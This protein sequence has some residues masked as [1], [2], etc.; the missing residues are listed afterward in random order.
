M[1]DKRTLS[2]RIIA[3]LGLLLTIIL[4]QAV[5]IIILLAEKNPESTS[6]PESASKSGIGESASH[7]EIL[8]TFQTGPPTSDP[9]EGIESNPSPLIIPPSLERMHLLGRTEIGRK[10]YG[11]AAAFDEKFEL[12]GE[13][14][15]ISQSLL[16]DGW[17]PHPSGLLFDDSSGDNQLFFVAHN[18]PYQF[19]INR[20]EFAKKGKGYILYEISQDDFRSDIRSFRMIYLDAEM[21]N[22]ALCRFDRKDISS[23]GLGLDDC[24]DVSSERLQLLDPYIPFFLGNDATRRDL[25]EE[26]FR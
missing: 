8:S 21:L 24:G 17:T 2:G 22:I 3:G 15:K 20:L 7:E 1:Q 18:Q 19:Q 13:L 10:A 14:G 12:K 23:L 11:W 6:G 5:I 25:L 9:L 16:A 4:V 26:I